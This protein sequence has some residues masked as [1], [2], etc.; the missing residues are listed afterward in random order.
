MTVLL[1]TVFALLLIYSYYYLFK[2][3]LPVPAV[4]LARA[5]KMTQK[6]PLEEAKSAVGFVLVSL[7]HIIF[8]LLLSLILK[9]HLRSL[10]IYHFSLYDCSF[11]LLLGPGLAGTTAIISLFVTKLYAILF[12]CS[13]QQIYL[14]L[15]SGWI[16]S[17]AAIKKL[18]PTYISIPLII[19]QLACEE[20]VFRVIF[21]NYFLAS[22]LLFSIIISTLLFVFM[23]IFLMPTVRGALFPVIGALMMGPIHGIA[24][25]ITHSI[26]PLIISHTAFF[27]MLTA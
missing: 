5:F 6:Y 12:S 20:F 15:S 8:V 22:G 7:S 25:T 18:T 23:Q 2:L 19:S 11:G 21:Q 10:N 1:E 17:Y 4:L 24:F 9:V 26:W 14:G 3:C 16:K 27:L 13:L